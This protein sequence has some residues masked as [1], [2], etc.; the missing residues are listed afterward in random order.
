MIL[1]MVS[2]FSMNE[3]YSRSFTHPMSLKRARH[4]ALGGGLKDVIALGA[5]R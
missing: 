5:S 2:C 3:K 4:G 1:K